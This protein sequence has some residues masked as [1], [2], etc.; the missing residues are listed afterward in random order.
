MLKKLIIAG[1]ATL[2]F[3]V[4]AYASQCPGDM[5]KID[6]AMTTA[7][8]SDTDKAEVMKLRAEGEQLHKSGSHP[9]SIATLAKAKAILKL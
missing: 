7:Q 6:A 1:V 5:A 8:L 9:D 3:S 2:A 4:S